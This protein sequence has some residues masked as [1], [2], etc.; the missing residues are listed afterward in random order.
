MIKRNP[1]NDEGK[2][3]QEGRYHSNGA[4]CINIKK[5]YSRKGIPILDYILRIR[6]ETTL[7]R[8]FTL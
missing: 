8:D 5:V 1:Q 2:K 6:R 4:D 3:Q 7:A